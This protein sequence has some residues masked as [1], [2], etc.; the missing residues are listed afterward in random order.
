MSG[1]VLPVAAVSACALA[2]LSFVTPSAPSQ[3]AQV[4]SS[5]RG[6]QAAPASGAAAP[7]SGAAAATLLGAA[8][9]L[10]CRRAK[11]APTAARAFENETGVQ[12]PIGFWDPAG[13]T[14]EDNQWLFNRRRNVELK[15]GRVAMLATIGYIVPNWA[16]F[17]GF[18][19]PSCGV[20][21]ADIPTGLAAIEKTPAAGIGQWLLW[22]G[23]FDLF[24][25][26]QED[27]YA[28]GQL[29]NR[30]IEK[31]G[32]TNWGYGFLGVPEAWGGKRIEDPE[33]RKQKLNSELANGRLAM[34]A[35]FA[36]MA[37]EG[38]VG[39]TGPDMWLG[40]HAAKGPL[41]LQGTG[42]PR[43]EDYW[44]PLNLAVG[45]SDEQLRRWRAV[46]LK[47]GRVAM[48]AVL[49][50]FHVAA[51]YHWIGDYALGTYA[52]DN[53]LENATQLTLQGWASIFFFIMVTEW[54]T[55]KLI[56][57]PAER[58]WDILGWSAII[59]DADHEDPEWKKVQAFELNN[60][61]LAMFGIM[62]LIFGDAYSGEYF[63]GIG[64]PLF[65]NTDLVEHLRLTFLGVIPSWGYQFPGMFPGQEVPAVFEQY[66]TFVLK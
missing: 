20:K 37:Q 32:G 23:A 3:G 61:R 63:A 65:G 45:K 2:G 35:F 15:H 40:L 43:P 33:V 7:R 62:G 16:K 5:L 38:V 26:A 60:S 47:N 12:A 51:G 9:L 56:P 6:Q 11:V 10:A 64:Q 13:F 14:N 18:I 39:N 29:N 66:P 24:A 36:M 49:G 21:F 58:P 28:P 41:I 4:S 27:Q 25:G 55:Q 42:G 52:S 53:P 30:F 19:S 46:E 57:P 50:W 59:A 17:P 1:R 54:V 34:I 8:A 44:D 31:A 48:L 22:C